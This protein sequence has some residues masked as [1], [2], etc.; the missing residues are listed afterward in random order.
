[1]TFPPVYQFHIYLQWVNARLELCLNS[2]LNVKE[3]LGAFNLSRA[4]IRDCKTSRNLREP[5]FEAL[6]RTW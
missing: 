5:W 6:V 1:M 4:L 2:V 3:L